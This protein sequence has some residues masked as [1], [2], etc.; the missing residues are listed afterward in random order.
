MEREISQNPI[1]SDLQFQIKLIVNNSINETTLHL[2]NNNP[3][4]P[5]VCGHACV[6]LE[7]KIEQKLGIDIKFCEGTRLDKINNHFCDYHCWL[8]YRDLIIDPTDFQFSI[9]D[10]LP[11]IHTLDSSKKTKKYS[12]KEYFNHLF[13]L[14]MED[15]NKINFFFDE[16]KQH[17]NCKIFYPK[18]DPRYVYQD[19][20]KE[21]DDT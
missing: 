5:R 9:Y 11:L 14:V 6:L 15:K 19:Y 20:L 18:S 10:R 21:I 13:N 16:L 4:F 7:D 1:E 17:F 8:E 3:F 12:K 2:M